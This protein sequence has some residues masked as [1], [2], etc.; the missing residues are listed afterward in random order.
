MIII[1]LVSV[2]AMQYL[3]RN[4]VRADHADS[5]LSLSLIFMSVRHSFRN[6]SNSIHSSKC[7][8]P[9]SHKLILPW[10]STAETPVDGIS[11]GFWFPGQCL[12]LVAGTRLHVSVTSLVP[13]PSHVFPIWCCNNDVS[14]TIST[15]RARNGGRYVI[16]T[17]PNRPGLPDFSRVRWKTWEGQG[18]RLLQSKF[19]YCIL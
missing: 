1:H 14:T 4:S 5:Y 2:L 8:G 9:C 13:R 17:S 7:R 19:S 3:D 12:Q 11:A 15:N 10:R 18:T 16:I 6:F